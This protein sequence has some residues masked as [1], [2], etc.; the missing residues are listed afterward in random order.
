VKIFDRLRRLHGFTNRHRTILQVASILHDG[1]YFVNA[2]GGCASSLLR[3]IEICGLSN[4]DMQLVSFIANFN[5]LLEPDF[6]HPSFCSFTE[7]ELLL[8]SKLTAIFRLANALDK[9]RKQKLRELR[10]KLRGDELILSA[11]CDQNLYLEQWAVQRCGVFFQE[12]FGIH[13]VLQIKSTM[14]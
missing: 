12:A 11:T 5:E 2:K 10:V 14:L 7:E 9:S 6:G 1:G 4:S 13:P 3:N 8:C